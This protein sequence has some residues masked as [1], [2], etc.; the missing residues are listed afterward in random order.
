MKTILQ[1]IKDEVF[2][3]VNDGM[4]ENK[5]LRRGMGTDDD[6]TKEALASNSFLG[7]L[8]DVLREVLIQAVNV[9]EGDKSVGAMT[10]LQRKALQ[11]RINGLYKEIG[12]EEIDLIQNPMVYINC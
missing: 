2:Y 8:A 9:S 12:E 7:A 3:P 10:D 1:A 5:I 6:A 4:V 11:K